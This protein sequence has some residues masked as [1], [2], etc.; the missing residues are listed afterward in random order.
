[1]TVTLGRLSANVQLVDPATGLPTRQGASFWNNFAT[2]IEQNIS[3]LIAQETELANQAAALTAQAAALAAQVA[4]IN[5]ILAG[6]TSV[7]LVTSANEWTAP[8]K[9]DVEPNSV[10]GYE[11]ATIQVVG[12]QQPTI[13]ALAGAATLAQ[14]ITAYNTLLASIKAHGLVAP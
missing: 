11:V 14:V 3:T 10:S 6:S 2:A 1:M 8:Q 13:A 5:N 12:A 4:V 7:A 9:F